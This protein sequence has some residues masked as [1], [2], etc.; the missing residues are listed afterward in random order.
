LRGKG[1]HQP[2]VNEG[3]CVVANKGEK[4]KGGTREKNQN[5]S[6]TETNRAQN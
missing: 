3:F 1:A 5:Q 6:E 4:F 2:D